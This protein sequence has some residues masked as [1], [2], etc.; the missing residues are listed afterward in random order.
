M[1]N[2]KLDTSGDLAVEDNRLVLVGGPDEVRQR[3]LIAMRTILG[4]WFLDQNVGIPYIPVDGTS[5]S[6]KFVTDK[7]ITQRELQRIFADASRRVPGVIQVNRVTVSD[8]DV[9]AR[10]VALEVEV[11][12]DDDGTATSATFTL[13]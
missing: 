5:Y 3:W 8:I 6:G 10:S 13:G 12:I 9:A 2:L 11:T 7:R 1:A 4:E